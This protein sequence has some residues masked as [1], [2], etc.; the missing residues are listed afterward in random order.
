MDPLVRINEV[1]AD[2]VYATYKKKRY[3][4]KTCSALIDEEVA[5]DL[6]N[7]LIRGNEMRVCLCEPQGF[8]S[9]SNV[10]E[11]INTI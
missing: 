1:F 5:D 11:K 9:L 8:C 6:R 10:E 4:L 2:A 3:G 7:I